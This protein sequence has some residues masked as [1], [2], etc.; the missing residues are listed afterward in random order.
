MWSDFEEWIR[1]VNEI[2]NAKPGVCWTPQSL[3]KKPMKGLGLRR[4][5]AI[6]SLS[7]TVGK[8]VLKYYGRRFLHEA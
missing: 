5:Y 4:K 7:C 2:R 8:P 1:G 3:A 6:S